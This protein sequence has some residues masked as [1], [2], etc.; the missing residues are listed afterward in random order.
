[1]LVVDALIGM[2]LFLTILG[3]IITLLNIKQKQAQK[4]PGCKN[5]KQPN[6]DSC[7][8]CGYILR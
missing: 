6:A 7:P 8:Y 1:M 2:G 5:P 4:C 3:G